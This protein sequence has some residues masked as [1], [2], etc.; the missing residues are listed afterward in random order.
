MQIKSDDVK[1]IL[2]ALTGTE[3]TNEEAEAL[4][5]KHP[6]SRDLLFHF[7]TD[8]PTLSKSSALQ[9]FLQNFSPPVCRNCLVEKNGA[10]SLVFAKSFMNKSLRL[11]LFEK[12][13]EYAAALGKIKNL[14]D[15]IYKLKKRIG[16]S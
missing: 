15:A 9:T 8:Q 13:K 2:K 4:S 16:D 12:Q 7:L 5:Q 10:D 1:Q 6:E 11:D 3:P 14:E